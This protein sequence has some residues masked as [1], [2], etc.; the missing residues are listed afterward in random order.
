L[1]LLMFK[2]CC[3]MWLQISHINDYHCNTHNDLS[4]FFNTNYCCHFLPL[5]VININSVRFDAFTVMTMKN[6]VLWDIKTQFIPHRKHITSPLQS[7]V[8]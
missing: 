7:P 6:A 2:Y 5:L 3:L 1:T 8:G 4:I